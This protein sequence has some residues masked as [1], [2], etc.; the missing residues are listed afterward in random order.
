[1]K[2]GFKEKK[3][4]VEVFID[5]NKV[6]DSVWIKGLLYKLSKIGHRKL[7]GLA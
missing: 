4:T 6:Y 5:N 1:M 7:L 3:S 2:S